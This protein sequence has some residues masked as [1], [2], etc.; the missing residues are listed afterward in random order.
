MST[1]KTTSCSNGPD[2]FHD[3]AVH[4]RRDVLLS[5]RLLALTVAG[6]ALLSGCS[7][8]APGSTSVSDTAGAG[9]G[10]PTTSEAR[11]DIARL[12]DIGGGRRLYLECRGS[13]SP[14]V[15]FVSGTGGAADEWMSVVDKSDPQAPP[16]LS[17]TSVFDTL[18]HTVR[19]CAY[20]RPGTTLASGA[21]AP[22]TLVPQPTTAGQADADLHA[23]L[24]AA[25]EP[26]P[27]LLVGASW[28]GLIAQSFARTHPSEVTGLVL[29][30]SAS[31]YL[32]DT[33]T[34]TQWSAWMATNAAA[35]AASPNAESPDYDASVAR[36]E[37][38]GPMPHVPAVVLS[39]DQPWDL[40]VTPGASTWPAWL[41]AQDRLARS[42]GA[43]HIGKTDS[44]HGI[45]VEQPELVTKAIRGVL[46]RSR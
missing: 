10:Q 40:G 22:S 25:H 24:A 38:D 9:P 16:V 12:V 21:L 39:S 44:G 7:A 31:V 28:G 42:L 4:R 27:Y 15:V 17:T 18:E 29:V 46:K 2:P 26:G 11:P 1:I 19:V 3:G 5:A 23:L 35:H 13:G 30:D 14:T 6:V 33:L 34:A 45:A 32:K 41:A 37:T 20:D 8:Q 36:L 43:E